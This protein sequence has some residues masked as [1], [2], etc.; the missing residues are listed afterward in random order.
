MTDEMSHGQADIHVSMTIYA[1]ASLD[2]QRKVLDLLA[3]LV[4]G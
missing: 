1:H 2:D 3:E 4:A